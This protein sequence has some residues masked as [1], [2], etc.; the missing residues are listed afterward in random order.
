MPLV[1]SPHIAHITRPKYDQRHAMVIFDAFSMNRV[2]SAYDHTGIFMEA[3]ADLCYVSIDAPGC[4][5]ASGQIIRV[6]P[7]HPHLEAVHRAVRQSQV[8]YQ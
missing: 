4:T 6:S 1:V 2:V 7:H 8:R 5:A 3:F